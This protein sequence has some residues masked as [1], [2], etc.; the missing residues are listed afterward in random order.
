[1]LCAACSPSMLT[2]AC[3]RQHHPSLR[4]AALC[5]APQADKRKKKSGK[6]SGNAHEFMQA[7]L[8]QGLPAL[9]PCVITS[10]DTGNAGARLPARHPALL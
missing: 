4:C 3:V 7:L 9:P 1:M 5:C 10:S 2:G 6:H 8:Q